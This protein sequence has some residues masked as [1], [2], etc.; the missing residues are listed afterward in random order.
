[1]IATPARQRKSPAHVCMN[2]IVVTPTW[3]RLIVGGGE[4]MLAPKIE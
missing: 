2:E 4:M 3:N 1:M